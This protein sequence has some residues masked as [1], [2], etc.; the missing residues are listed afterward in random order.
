MGDIFAPGEIRRVNC[1]FK[2]GL[3]LA[4]RLAIKP[5]RKISGSRVGKDLNS[6]V[7]LF[8]YVRIW[9]IDK[10]TSR[11]V[12]SNALFLRS[13]VERQK[14]LSFGE[15]NDSPAFKVVRAFE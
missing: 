13:V 15:A 12:N 4:Q 9:K 6:N 11:K 14:A 3:R 1:I 2:Q 10:I 8:W 5:T 7:L